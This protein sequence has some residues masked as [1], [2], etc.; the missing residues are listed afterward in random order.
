MAKMTSSFRS[1]MVLLVGLSMFLS[2]IITSL[3]FKGLQYY[4][5]R[6]AQYGDQLS[7]F[8]M[9]I[10]RIGDLPL[11]FLFFLLLSL[12]FFYFFTKPYATYFK[13]ISNGIHYLARGDFTH[14]VEIRSND[15]FKAIARDINLASE[16][17]KEAI[18]RG[19]FS[20]SSKDQLI[21]NLAHDLR[22]PLTSVIGYLDLT[23]KEEN[24]TQEQVRHFLTIAFT[25]SQR[26]EGL[27]D[28]L[29]EI[30]RMNY[31]ML[32]VNKKRINLTDLLHQ[33]KEELYPVFEQN[34]L[35]VRMEADPHLFILGDGDL[36]ARVFENLLTN[37]IRYGYEGQYVDINGYK[38]NNEVV[39]EIVNYGDEIPPDNLPHIFDMFY[40]GDKSRTHR[41]DS[42][43]LGLFIAKNI[44][45]Q[46]NGSITA[47]SNLIQTTFEV[48]IPIESAIYNDVLS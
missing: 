15:E 4:Y 11:F 40:T 45:D 12:L 28:E 19:D 43:G 17:L 38:Q 36:L 7:E 29:F 14:Q 22:T 18:Q 39:V 9:L 13:E 46:H 44:V 20:E 47:K 16:T 35:K 37:A 21:V 48:R 30:T 27:I 23:L 6:N 31:G 10:G 2:G 5:H 32:P 34:H 3:I 1:K 24:L 41:E 25:K 33:L 8:R 26:L 42:T